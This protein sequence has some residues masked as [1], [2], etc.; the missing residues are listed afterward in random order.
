VAPRR[1]IQADF[2]AGQAADGADFL[3][4]QDSVRVHEHADAAID[5]KADDLVDVFVRERFA[6]IER[7]V[8]HS[9]LDELSERFQDLLARHLAWQRSVPIAIVTSEIAEVSDL[10]PDAQGHRANSR[11]REGNLS[12]YRWIHAFS[13]SYSRFPNTGL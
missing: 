3:L 13:V 1:A 6:A 4:N 12:D 8:P 7:D 2:D 11:P 10:E 5:Q 9:E